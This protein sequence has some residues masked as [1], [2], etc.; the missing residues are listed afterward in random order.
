MWA[1]Y[2]RLDCAE[3]YFSHGRNSM[4]RGNGIV[5]S[6]GQKFVQSG[7]SF[8]CPVLLLLTSPTWHC[9]VEAAFASRPI[10]HLQQQWFFLHSHFWHPHSPLLTKFLSDKNMLL[11]YLFVCLFFIGHNDGKKTTCQRFLLPTCFWV[12]LEVDLASAVPRGWGPN[13]L[14]DCFFL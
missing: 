12:K 10:S 11:I 7:F 1:S 2:D 6:F 3:I 4:S 14:T 5:N 9:Q 13:S 8:G